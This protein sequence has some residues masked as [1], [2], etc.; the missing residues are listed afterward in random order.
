MRKPK[1]GNVNNVWMAQPARGAGLA[2]E[3]RDKLFIAHELRRD[4]LERNVALRA[5]VSGKIHGAHAATAKQ[6][7]EAILLVKHLTNVRICFD[8]G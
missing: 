8:H 2:L 1:V 3:A 5:Q 6:T 7:L 4:Q